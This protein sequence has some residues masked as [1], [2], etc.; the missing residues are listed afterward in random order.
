MRPS[1]RQP[2]VDGCDQQWLVQCAQVETPVEAIAERREIA[3]GI[4]LKVE[5]MEPHRLVLRLP[6]TV[7]IHLKSGTSL[8]LRPAMTVGWRL[9]PA[10]VTAPKQANP[11]ENTT[12]P[13]ATLPFAHV[14][15]PHA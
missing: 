5:G 12:L 15:S 11:S 14:E 13:G 6:R 4:F 3:R 2:C 8:G 9:Q 10:S 1:G 7:L